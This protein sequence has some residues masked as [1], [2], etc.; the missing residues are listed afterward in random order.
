MLA[1]L[2]NTFTQGK[3]ILI[4]LA[5][6][7]AAAASAYAY[8]KITVLKLE[9]TVSDQNTEIQRL[10]ADIATLQSNQAILEGVARENQETIERLQNHVAD[11]V[12]QA[13]RLTANIQRLESEKQ[14]Y[15]SIFREHDLTKLSRAKPGLIENRINQGTQDVF[16]NLEQE[17]Q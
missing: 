7:T 4:G 5:I 14:K 3:L 11:Q 15:L 13:Q 8:H 6:V 16:R 10:Q 12:G 17:T 9:N 2:T 1:L